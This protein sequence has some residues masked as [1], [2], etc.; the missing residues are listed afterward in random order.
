MKLSAMQEQFLRKFYALCGDYYGIADLEASPI[1]V[2]TDGDCF[3]Q[4]LVT[5]HVTYHQE[6]ER[7][8]GSRVD[9]LRPEGTESVKVQDNRKNPE[10][11]F[12]IESSS[13]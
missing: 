12:R 9:T 5:L 2:H 4:I 8:E 6:T 7:K 1:K 3:Y 13:A 10:H 11:W